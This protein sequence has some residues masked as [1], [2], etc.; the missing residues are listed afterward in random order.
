GEAFYSATDCRQTLPRIAAE[1]AAG[2][3]VIAVGAMQRHLDAC[4]LT[5]H[6]NLMLLGRIFAEQRR[7]DHTRVHAP[8]H[9]GCFVDA[10]TGTAD[11]RDFRDLFAEQVTPQIEVSDGEVDQCA[12]PKRSLLSIR[13]EPSPKV[14]R[15]AQDAV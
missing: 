7:R 13:R 2:T 4:S 3:E 15:C 8:D 12:A 9:G 11:R 6:G 1:R 14:V 10:S 5:V